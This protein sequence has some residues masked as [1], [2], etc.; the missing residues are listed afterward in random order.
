MG[1]VVGHG[2][3]SQTGEAIILI[4]IIIQQQ[5][6]ARPVCVNNHS[7]TTKV[8]VNR[9]LTQP[10]GLSLSHA[11]QTQLEIVW[12]IILLIFFHVLDLQTVSQIT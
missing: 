7:F 5:M 10:T 6:V 2:E 9:V 3:L 1:V 8:K 11:T 12:C 4:I